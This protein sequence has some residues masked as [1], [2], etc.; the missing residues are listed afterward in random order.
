MEFTY[1]SKDGEEGFPGNLTAHVRYSLSDANELKLEYAATTDKD[2]VVNLTNHSYF[3]LGGQGSGDVLNAELTINAD[4]YTPVD[5]FSI[6]TGKLVDV[7]GT[8][9]DFRQPHK[10]GERIKAGGVPGGYDHNF[11]LN[12]QDGLHPAA[13]VYDGTTGRVMEVSTTEPGVQLYTSNGLNGSLAGKDGKKYPKFGAVC[14]E[15]EHFPDSPNEPA[16]P[17][18]E[19]KPGDMYHSMTVYKFSTRAAAT[20]LP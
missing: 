20:T 14:L 4:Q 15:A 1:L 3:N 17:S 13:T 18:T 7:A 9:F 6:P 8:P 12:G 2:T 10:I 19:L 16:F 5:N 11:V